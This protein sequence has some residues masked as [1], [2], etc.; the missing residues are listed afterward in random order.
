ML[1]LWKMGKKIDIVSIVPVLHHSIVP[2]PQSL[3]SDP[4]IV[5]SYQ[6]CRGMHSKDGRNVISNT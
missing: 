6:S 3:W 4:A 1:E 5:F 2:I